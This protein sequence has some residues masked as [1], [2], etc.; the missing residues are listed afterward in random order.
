MLG[1]FE[2]LCSADVTTAGCLRQYGKVLND[3]VNRAVLL[4]P[5]H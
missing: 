1:I 5:H 2:M 3:L 4:N